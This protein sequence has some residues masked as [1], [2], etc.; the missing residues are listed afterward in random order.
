MELP[1]IDLSGLPD[2]SGASGL[3]GTLSDLATAGTD[4]RVLVIMVFIY[5]TLPPEQLGF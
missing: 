4:D 2:L 3:F 1:K 5:E